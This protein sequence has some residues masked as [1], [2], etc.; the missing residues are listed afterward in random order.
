MGPLFELNAALVDVRH[1]HAIRVHH[2]KCSMKAGV[3]F[4]HPVHQLQLI[5]M[6][7]AVAHRESDIVQK[8]HVYKWCAPMA[9]L[10]RSIR[11]VV[12]AATAVNH[13]LGAKVLCAMEV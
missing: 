7:V 4:V 12:R 11:T 1:I 2:G 8:L 13:F 5:H 10:K 3:P 9:R 6:H